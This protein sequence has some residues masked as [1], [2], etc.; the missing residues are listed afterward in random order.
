VLEGTQAPELYPS[1]LVHPANGDLV[2]LVDQAAAS[3]LS[4]KS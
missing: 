4:K 2:W 3:T 1:K